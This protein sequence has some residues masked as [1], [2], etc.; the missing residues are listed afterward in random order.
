[1]AAGGVK[2]WLSEPDSWLH[3]DDDGLVLAAVRA[4]VGWWRGYLGIHKAMDRNRLR[5]IRAHGGLTYKKA[6]SPD[7]LTTTMLMALSVSGYEMP[8]FWIG[9]DC[10]HRGDLV[11]EHGWSEGIYRDLE[12]VRGE[13]QRMADQVRALEAVSA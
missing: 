8:V 9:F 11:P 12:F 7:S 2:P 13:I 10:G 4:G 5:G 1:V 3:I 6:E